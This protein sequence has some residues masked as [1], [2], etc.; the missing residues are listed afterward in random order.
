MGIL[1]LTT[2]TV[3]VPRDRAPDLLE[4]AVEL[5]REELAKLP[6]E[7]DPR[8][9]SGAASDQGL[10]SIDEPPV[11]D[12][13]IVQLADHRRSH[14][15]APSGDRAQTAADHHGLAPTVGEAPVRFLSDEQLGEHLRTAHEQPTFVGTYP[16][17]PAALHEFFHELTTVNVKTMEVR[18]K[19]QTHSHG[20]GENYKAVRWP[21]K[22]GDEAIAARVVSASRSSYVGAAWRVLVTSSPQNRLTGPQLDAA[23][24]LEGRRRNGVLARMS[25]SCRIYGRVSPWQWDPSSKTYW[26]EPLQAD[27]FSQALAQDPA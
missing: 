12:P 26:M 3:T 19:P 8:S 15:A 18:R 13:S 17:H 14:G 24:G 6:A 23:V 10:P 7:L 16:N 9:S 21:W 11:R 2:V 25:A 5:L 20:G 22:A 27:L 4:R 1:E